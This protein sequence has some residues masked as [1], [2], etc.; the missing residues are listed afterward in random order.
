[1]VKHIRITDEKLH[2]RLLKIKLKHGFSSMEAMIKGME[3]VYISY[4]KQ[5][6]SCQT[7]LKK[8]V[9]NAGS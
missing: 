6:L 2:K 1:M 4:R 3:K 5:L 9:I 8:S 7:K